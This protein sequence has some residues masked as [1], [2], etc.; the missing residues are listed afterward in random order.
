MFGSQTL[1]IAVGL[2][3]LFLLVSIMLTALN[4]AIEAKLKTRA[5]DL[6]KAIEQLLDDPGSESRAMVEK[7]YNHPLIFSLFP[8]GYVTRVK[9]KWFGRSSAP[10][11]P[12]YIPRDLFSGAVLDMVRRGEASDHVKKL[13]GRIQEMQGSDLSRTRT[14]LENWFDGTMDRAAGWYKRRTQ[15]QLFWLG[16]ALAI[17]LNLN[18]IAVAQYLSQTPAAR[19]RLVAMA[20]N[21]TE[22]SA[23]PSATP[24]SQSAPAPCAQ[25]ESGWD[26]VSACH[27][28]ISDVALPIGWS[29]FAWKRTFPETR[30][31]PNSLGAVGSWIVASWLSIVVAL[32]GWAITGLAATLGAP[33]WFDMLNKIMVVRSTVKPREKSGDEASEDRT[34]KPA[35]TI[36]VQQPRAGGAVAGTEAK[37]G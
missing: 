27:K 19:D 36:V 29:E 5:A 33:F 6:E 16:F 7:F 34:L 26:A 25:G 11:L 23:A 1:D 3:L 4:E 20:Q 10:N 37:P 12:S 31:P 2:V 28:A 13:V 18:P 8:D 15:R 17:A 35:P 22:S 24:S 30:T 32:I 9:S 14:Q 21:V